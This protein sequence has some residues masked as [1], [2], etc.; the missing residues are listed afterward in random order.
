MSIIIKEVTSSADRKKFVNLPFEIYRE[1]KFWV[2]SMKKDE[3]HNIMPEHNPAFDFCD[4]KFWIAMEGGRCVGR[5]GAI[6]NHKYNKKTGENLGRICRMELLDD[7]AISNKLFETA[8]AWLKEKGVDGVLGPLGFTNLDTQG[9][10]IEGFDQLPSIASVY[11]MPYYQVHFEKNGYQKEID[12]VEF[13]LFIK[14]IPEKASKL[15][16]LIRD[17]YKLKIIECK[18]KKE[19]MGYAPKVFALLNSA[20]DELPFVT[21]FD[22]KMS[23]YY[24]SKYFG[25]LNVKFVRLIETEE[26]NL[27]GFIIGVPSLSEA[28]QKANGSLFPFGFIHILKALKKPEVLDL[29]LTGVDPKLQSMGIPAILIN[30]L[31]KEIIRQ[32]I[33]AVE[34][35]G[36]FETNH[37]A[38]VTWKNYEH[39]QHKRRRCYRKMFA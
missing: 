15:A 3:L 39:I 19:L 24:I 6:I 31:Q 36:I 17:R 5:I 8:E 21:A 13:R 10:L 20:F 27:A 11:H 18:T 16:N 29:F 14:E 37:K 26:G 7:A 30:E 35:T 33:H 38:I 22:E 2:P 23:Q 25:S 28:F 4:A 9:L 12:W 1:N 32:N 34:T